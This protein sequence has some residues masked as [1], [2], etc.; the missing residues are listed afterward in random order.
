MKSIKEITN[1]ELASFDESHLRKQGIDV[2]IS[3]GACVSIYSS[4]RYVS[5]DLDLIN[6]RC[7]LA[8]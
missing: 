5:I 6:T 3:G 2:V 8:S 7:R 4:N 1:A